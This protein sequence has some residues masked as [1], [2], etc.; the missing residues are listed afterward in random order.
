MPKISNDTEYPKLDS[1]TI[2]VLDYLIG[3]Q[4]GT[5]L[6]KNFPIGVILAAV[7][8]AKVIDSV[9]LSGVSTYQNDAFIGANGVWA[10][11]DGQQ[12]NTVNYIDSFDSVTGTITFN[13]L[14]TPITG[15]MG[16]I[17]F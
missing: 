17:Y 13:A 1:G 3:T 4:N 15:D 11:Y 12:L 14:Y 16:F 6:T 5:L 10:F 7:N 8:S 2:N 9:P